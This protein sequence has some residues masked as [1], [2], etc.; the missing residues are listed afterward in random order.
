MYCIWWDGDY[1]LYHFFYI[2]INQHS[3]WKTS[4]LT[5]S[6]SK[7]P[8]TQHQTSHE[9]HPPHTLSVRRQHAA[10][11]PLGNSIILLLP[12]QGQFFRALNHA[13]AAG[14]T[15]KYYDS[16]IGMVGRTRIGTVC[17]GGWQHFHSQQG[18]SCRYKGSE[19]RWYRR[20]IGFANPRLLLCGNQ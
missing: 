13:G 18:R 15:P 8:I 5:I 11:P 12:H 14:R 9:Q 2:I 16:A 4:L 10:R 19:L 1:N 17:W 20:S 3:S 7:P 6:T